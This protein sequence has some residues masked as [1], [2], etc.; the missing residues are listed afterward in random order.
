MAATEA[1]VVIVTGAAGGIGQ[2]IVEGVLAAGMRV[3]GTDFA[4]SGL[5]ALRRRW[6]PH[7]AAGT[8][9]VHSADLTVRTAAAELV[10]AAVAAFGRIDA[11]VNNAGIGHA[12]MPGRAYVTRPG[13][14]EVD[15]ATWERFFAINATAVFAVAGAALPHLRASQCG[16]IVN[17]TTSLESMLRKGF[18]PYGPSK[19]AAEALTA[20]MAADLAGSGVTAN[21]LVP[22]GPTDTAMVPAYAPFDRASLLRPTVMVPPLLWLLSDAAADVSGQRFRACYWDPSIDPAL[23]A[24]AAMSPVAWTSLARG[25]MWLPQGAAL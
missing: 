21:V 17:V 9:I 18:T 20:I 8:L 1:R 16:R 3:V 12:S 14:W 25:D 5:E 13:F 7:I 10:D 15:L 6:S 4:E 23:A 22:G 2:A 11:V 24:A 19:A